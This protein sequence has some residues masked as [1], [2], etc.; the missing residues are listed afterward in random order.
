MSGEEG[1]LVWDDFPETAL[2]KTYNVDRQVPDSA[3][4]ATAYWTGVK[5]NYEVNSGFLFVNVAH[6]N[7]NQIESNLS[8]PEI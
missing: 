3:G 2:L 4:T 6:L 1:S 7:R 5:T 8:V